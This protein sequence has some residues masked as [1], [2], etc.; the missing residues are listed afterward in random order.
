MRKIYMQSIIAVT[1]FCV[2]GFSGGTNATVISVAG[3]YEVSYGINMNPGSSNGSVIESVFF[4]EWDDSNFSVEFAGTIAGSGNTYL[5]HVIDFEPTSALLIG[6]G[7]AVPGVGDEKDHL[8]TITSLAFSYTV[9]GFKWSEAFPGVPPMPRVGHN[10]MIA[11]LIDAEAGSSG[12]LELLTNF[13][14]TEGDIAAF[15][16]DKS[17]VVLEWST[18]PPGTVGTRPNCVPVGSSIPEPATIIL[19]TIGLA[20]L[21]L[22]RKKA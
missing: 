10:A 1:L 9:G 2:L 19:F 5:S 4:F 13:V 14:V 18:C 11:A 12:A 3:G 22:R 20:G 8:Y 15:N 21:G 7:A 17:F 6:Y 16:P